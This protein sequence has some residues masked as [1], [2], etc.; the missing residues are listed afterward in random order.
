MK[1]S[2]I[3]LASLLSVVFAAA[4]G[5][6]P[7][8]THPPENARD[9]AD[10]LIE[11]GESIPL[12]AG[13]PRLIL[14]VVIDQLR[15]DYL[16]RFEDLY[17]GGFRTLLERGALF[18]EA[19]YRHGVNVTAVGHATI[20]TGR[21]P[22][23]HGIV[24][25]RWY[26][27]ALGRDVG[28]V[29]DS[30]YEPVAGPGVMAS[31]RNLLVPTLGDRLKQSDRRSKTV[32]IGTKDRV[33]VLLAGTSGDGAYWFSEDC[34]CFITSSY[35][36]SEAP[37]WLTNFRLRRP[38]DSYLGKPWT[39]L[40]D[41]P[42]LYSERSR[43][44]AFKAENDGRDI[45][46][47][48]I[49]Q[50]YAQL[51]ETH[52]YDEFVFDAVVEAM[53]FH[54]IGRDDVTD[55][56]A[57]GFA[58]TD[59]IGH[60]FGPFSQEAM[61]QHLRLDLLLGRLWDVVDKRVGLENTIVVLTADHGVAPLVAQSRRQGSAARGVRS[62]LF[63]E[64]VDRAVAEHFGRDGVVAYVDGGHVTLD[65][66]A[67]E[68]LGLKREE[69]ES[70]AKKALLEIDA[71]AA[72]YTHADLRAEHDSDDPDPY[73][74]LYRN[75]VYAGRSPHLLVQMK[76]FHYT[77]KT[78]GHTTHVSAHDYDRHIPIFVMG[79]GV[80]PGRYDSP[81]GPED[82]TPTLGAML[83]LDIEPEPDARVLEELVF[84]KV[85]RPVSAG[86]AGQ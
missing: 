5:C 39:H 17:T 59:H 68:R 30:A 58:A 64:A 45:V 14:L 11:A 33:A 65:L 78:Q 18:T 13:A 25:N 54:E 47:P 29:E 61:D 2:R 81:S 42:E 1:P 24:G 43:G 41:D 84:E 23:H 73:R 21:H 26:D 52:N 57:V 7:D 60:S 69:V 82:I 3:L 8:P 48:H 12:P 51:K 77:G 56:L 9:R 20:V 37:A 72:V 35:F 15:Y 31:P 50:T 38:A 55:F 16:T 79:G 34:G 4:T 44:D 66:E 40:L 86:A 67:I 62:D 6:A 22:S 74:E 75:A 53:A 49:P 28:A 71:V 76:P 32:G 19:R 46:F 10:A 83:G 36:S 80:A 85:N 70:V 27:P 63:R